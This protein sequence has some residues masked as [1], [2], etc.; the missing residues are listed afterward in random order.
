[1]NERSHPFRKARAVSLTTFKRDGTAV[2]T[3][4]WFYIDGDKLYTTTHG[5]A[6]KLKRLKNNPS[7]EIAVCTQGGKVTGPVYVGTA[8]ALSAV[9]TEAVMK[10][11]QRRYPIHRLMVMLPKMKGQIGL[12][13]IPGDPKNAST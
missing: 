7:V 13:I 8:R 9:E 4:M 12:E 11:K 1:M 5:S 10:R 6:A 3:A 2:S